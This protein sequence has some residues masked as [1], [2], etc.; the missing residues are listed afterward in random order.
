MSEPPDV[1]TGAQ[2]NPSGP[3][4]RRWRREEIASIA[5]IIASIIALIVAISS[6][7]SAS[8]SRAEAQ[9]SKA[10]AQQSKADAQQARADAQRVATDFRSLQGSFEDAKGE[11]R[12]RVDELRASI[13]PVEGA[14]RAQQEEV[15]R[16]KDQT[17]R[18]QNE[19][20]EAKNQ[21]AQ[22]LQT[23][24]QVRGQ[25]LNFDAVVAGARSEL[26]AR[27]KALENN[28]DATILEQ[29]PI[30]S[31]LMWPLTE[32]PPSK[33]RICDGG[34]VTAQEAPEFCALFKNAA[35]T[36]E[37]GRVVHVPDLRGYFIRG[38]DTR[39]SQ[40]P[41]KIDEDAPR[42]VGSKQAEKLPQH[43][44]DVSDLRV[45]GGLWW[46][47]RSTFLYQIKGT[48]K[49]NGDLRTLAGS[50]NEFNGYQL[51]GGVP[52]VDTIAINGKL[53]PI[54]GQQGEVRP[55]NIALHFIIR[56]QR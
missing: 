27:V 52:E 20:T 45:A 24:A 38:A 30:G 16:L 48:E 37:S 17:A 4:W 10:D 56:V 43:T 29:M 46:P 9:Q 55:D 47:E 53:G 49:L 22:A 50:G 19:L 18:S 13:T 51:H 31:V 12:G 40:D 41:E 36:T 1:R 42:A 26:D 15:P 23:V 34:L 7:R 6:A 11:M 39:Q 3:N 25:F 35:W 33:W 54:V 14:L 21:Y 2:P 5:A 28:A 44:H 32:K 8:Q